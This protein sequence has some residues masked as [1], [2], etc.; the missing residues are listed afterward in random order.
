MNRILYSFIFIM[1]HISVAAQYSTYIDRMLDTELKIAQKEGSE[2]LLKDYL[3]GID[4]NIENIYVI[5]FR[6]MNCP[7]CEAAIRACFKHLKSIDPEAPT[8]IITAYENKEA[9]IQYNEMQK[10]E[11]DYY[12]YD[13]NKR[14]KEIFSFNSFDL[15]VVYFL[16]INRK[17]G[18]LMVGGD[19]IYVNKN[20]LKEVYEYSS[21]QPYS[22]FDKDLQTDTLELMIDHSGKDFV[23]IFDSYYIEQHEELAI[24]TTMAGS[25]LY[26]DYFVFTDQLGNAG[27]VFSFNPKSNSYELKSVLRADSSER[28]QFINLPEKVYRQHDQ[29]GMLFYIANQVRMIDSSFLISY[30]LPKAFIEEESQ[31]VALYNEPVLLK[32]NISDFT[33]TPL[34]NFDFNIFEDDYVYTHFS[35]FPIND[36]IVGVGCKR[37]TWPLELD[38]DEYK[39]NSKLDPFLDSFYEQ[40]NPIIALFN[41]RTGKKHKQIGNLG[42]AQ[43]MTKTGYFYLEPL[44]SAYNDQIIYCN[45]FDG[46]IFITTVSDLDINTD[47]IKVFDIDLS[48]VLLSDTSSFYQLDHAKKYKSIFN[49]KI[50]DIRM[51]KDI[52]HCIVHEGEWGNLN[53]G[54]FS[55]YQISVSSHQNLKTMFFRKEKPSQY[56]H[57]VGLGE[58]NSKI[59]PYLF[60]QENKD[61]YLKIPIN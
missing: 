30:S 11:A 20:F 48:Q 27:V 3:S 13:E 29:M 1:L 18:R 45:G 55:Y 33:S 26:N 24:S 28:R 2:N 7:R 50:I 37:N 21:Y 59:T 58:F 35:F 8:L 34:T 32:R 38:I 40:Q 14:Y 53:N 56:I 44:A 47:A 43:K 6:P 19:P 4:N 42:M 17:N 36:S 10:Y 61:H 60:L 16:K 25:S 49:K 51:D 9:A 23:S 46:E 12:V 52:I 15:P 5:I 39:G 41:L 54:F 22:S 57:H 31:K